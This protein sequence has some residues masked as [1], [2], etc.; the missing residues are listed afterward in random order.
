MSPYKAK[1]CKGFGTF[2]FKLR[3]HLASLISFFAKLYERA[4]LF[5]D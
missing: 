2:A 1:I 5:G 3:L 4:I